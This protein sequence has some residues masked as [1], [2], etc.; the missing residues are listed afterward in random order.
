MLELPE[1][2]V[3][4]RGRRQFA[5]SCKEFATWGRHLSATVSHTSV[6]CK[7]ILPTRSNRAEIQKTQTVA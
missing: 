6:E 1:K 3:V 5:P 2:E 4:F 7:G